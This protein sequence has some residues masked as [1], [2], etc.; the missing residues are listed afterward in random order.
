MKLGGVD[1]L[2][3]VSGSELAFYQEAIAKAHATGRPAP[4]LVT[5]THEGVAL[6]AALGNTMVT[7]QPAAT[8]VHVDAGTLHQGAAIHAAWRGGYPVL[9]TA[10]TGPRA[11]PGTMA[12]A[13]D[14][15]IQWLQEPRDQAAILRQYT[16]MDHR[17]EHQ[18][19][20]G[21][22]V[23]RLLQ[24]A[25]SAP[26]GP[27][28]LSIP[29]ETAMLPVDGVARFPTLDQLGV[30]RPC[31]PDPED[32]REIA[33]WLVDADDPVICT[34]RSG[35]DP[36]SIVALLH[37]AELLAIPVAEGFSS[38][39]MNFPTT[40]WAY[41]TGPRVS[42]ADVVLV[43]DGVAP[44]AAGIDSPRSDAKVVWVTADPV[45]SRFKTVEHQVDRWLSASVTAVATAVH[46][47]ATP[48]LTSDRQRRI[49]ERRQRLIARKRELRARDETS[50]EAD[51]GRGQLTGRAVAYALSRILEPDAVLLNDGVSNGPFVHSYADRTVPGTYF[52]SGSSA[53]GWG[54]GAAIGVKLAAPD[55]DVVHATGDGYFMFGSPLSALWAAA[56]NRTAYLTVIFVNGSYST[57]T[58]GV[59]AAYPNGYAVAGGFEG[60]TFDPPPD[61]AKLAE[62]TGSYGEEVVH[63]SDLIPALNRGLQYTR[64]A[65]PAVIA[66]RV[67][68]TT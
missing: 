24:V 28:Y 61:F 56:H 15:Q 57:G 62:S 51:I 22:M 54:T 13:R 40:H 64:E 34:E 11:F 18:D 33:R 59:Q 12:G 1:N 31:W 45:L 17:L 52:R 5:L 14:H 9:M 19:N 58:S 50:A 36:A 39:R 47:A 10:G 63:A 8:A 66:I 68:T 16:K 2:F 53:G 23:S 48:L 42:D 20:P 7:N 55:R 37:L 67:P 35:R 26:A 21:F 65:V 6:N 44:F 3:F 27:V 60:G 30:A 38:D 29:R 49:E 32:A 46:D 4:R 25:V 41:G 43:M